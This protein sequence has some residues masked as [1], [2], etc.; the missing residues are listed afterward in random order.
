MTIIEV[1]AIIVGPNGNDEDIYGG[2]T[3]SPPFYQV[4]DTLE[5]HLG[6][7]TKELLYY[8]HQTKDSFIIEIKEAANIN[9]YIDI[10]QTIYQPFDIGFIDYYKDRRLR[11]KIIN[12]E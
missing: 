12:V 10:I 8:N 6:E 7:E 2:E 3:G 5:E 11:F 4:K 9:H 1:E